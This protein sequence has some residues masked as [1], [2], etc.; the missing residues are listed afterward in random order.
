MNQSLIIMETTLFEITAKMHLHTLIVQKTVH[1]RASS[2][3][4]GLF[5]SHDPYSPHSLYHIFQ[6]PLHYNNSN[7]PIKVIIRISHANSPSS[8]GEIFDG[9]RDHKPCIHSCTIGNHRMIQKGSHQMSSKKLQTRSCPSA[10]RTVI[11]GPSVK[12]TGPCWK[13]SGQ[14]TIPCSQQQH[15]YQCDPP[16][17]IQPLFLLKISVSFHLSPC[18]PSPIMVI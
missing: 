3:C 1:S 13:F 15:A 7:R 4:R 8:F 5:F 18:N 16:S 6:Y 9:M 14:K 2:I 17:L 12:Q 10:S 11:S